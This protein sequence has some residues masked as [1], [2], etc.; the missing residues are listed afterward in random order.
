MLKRGWATVYEAKF[1]S[2]FG[3]AEKE[4][5]YRETEATAQQKKI[6]MWQQQGL[7]QK[8][9]GKSAQTFESPRAYKTRMQKE[10]K[11]K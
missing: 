2:E 6:G 11:K 8:M 10:E 9:L 3:G 7:V 4:K 5:L 1:G